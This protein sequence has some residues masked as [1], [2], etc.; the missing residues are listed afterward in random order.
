[1]EAGVYVCATAAGGHRPQSKRGRNRDIDLGPVETIMTGRE[2]Y[3]PH[4]EVSVS[5]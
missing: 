2:L 1:M 5:V 3:L 4:S